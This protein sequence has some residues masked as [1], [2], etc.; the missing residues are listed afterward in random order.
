MYSEQV[1]TITQYARTPQGFADVVTFAITTQ[2]QHFY[3]VKSIMQVI[4]DYGVDAPTQLNK[5]QKYAIAHIKMHASKY[6]YLPSCPLAAM[7][8][9]VELPSIGIVKAGF[10]L[11]MLSYP[12]IG[13]LD[14]HNCRNAGLSRN[15]F[16]RVPTSTENLMQRLQVYLSTCQ[17][18]GGAAYL[19]DSWCEHIAAK[20][21]AHFEN[22]EAVSMYHV[23]CVRGA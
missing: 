8:R 16:S 9:L 15:I 23:N 2:N 14:V 10:I 20:Y 18:L 11:Q 17:I 1:P 21:P 22:A 12:G 5:R 3:H 4:H 6:V 13:C 7:R 19:W